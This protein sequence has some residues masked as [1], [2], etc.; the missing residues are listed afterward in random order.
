M[1][2]ITHADCGVKTPK[3]L[4]T[5]AKIR[6]KS[7]PTQAVG[8]VCP[9]KGVSEAEA[10]GQRACDPPHLFAEEHVVVV[11]PDA[12]GMGQREVKHAH[13]KGHPED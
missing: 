11:R 4:N 5:P 12:V 3:T 8:P 7:G 13:R 1:V 6:G 2:R 10:G 9:L